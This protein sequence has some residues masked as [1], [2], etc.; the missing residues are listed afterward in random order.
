MLVSSFRGLPADVWR[1][2]YRTRRVAGA[3]V[4]PVERGPARMSESSM[5]R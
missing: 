5:R 4:T 2:A 3:D 1:K